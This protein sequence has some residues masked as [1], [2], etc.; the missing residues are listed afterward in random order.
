MRF[1]I[2]HFL[3]LFS[4]SFSNVIAAEK[5]PPTPLNFLSE[6]CLDCHD[7]DSAKGKINL[8]LLEIDWASPRHPKLLE[9][10]HR[11]LENG[12]MPPPKKKTQPGDDEREAMLGWLDQSLTK[13]IP[14]GGTPLR[15]LNRGEYVN[16]V[17][18]LFG[19]PFTLPPSFPPDTRLHGFDNQGEGLVL[20][21]PLL[22]A[23][24]ES[25]A[26]IADQFFPPPLPPVEKVRTDIR[27]SDMVISYSSAQRV[28]GA[29]RLGC[30]SAPMSR[31]C[32]WPTK[33]ETKGSGSYKIQVQSTAFKPRDDQPLKLQ[34]R[35]R[36]LD[37]NDGTRVD[38]LRLLAEFDV[39]AG[40][41][42]TFEFTADL[43]RGETLVY[44]FA[45]AELD[46]DN[47][48]KDE[49]R[50]LLE[51]MFRN[52]KRLLAAWMSVEHNQGLRGGV[53]WKRVKTQ[54]SRKDLDLSL[55]DIESEAAQKMIDGMIKNPVN[56]V[57]TIIYQYFEQGPALDIRKTIV[58]GPFE[59]VED[60]ATK[61]QKR[62]RADFLGEQGTK[63]EPEWIAAAIERF[64][65]QAFRRP[66][67]ANLVADYHKL[68]DQHRKEGHDLDASMH[69]VL[70]T[71]LTS[72]NF[73]YRDKGDGRLD[74]FEFASR[75]SYFL[76]S[77][78]PDN[79]LRDAALG[80]R[81]ANLKTVQF[82]AGRLLEDGASQNF[83]RSF[84]Q[85]WLGL[86]ELI[87]IMP[88]P[89]FG[90]FR[91]SDRK[92]MES[93]AEMFFAEMIRE[94]RP[95]ADF[96]TPDFTFTNAD[97]GAAIY[98][99]KFDKTQKK[100]G[101]QMIRVSLDPEGTYGGILGQAGVMM[102][103]ANGVD[104]QPVLRGV[105]VLENVLG[106][107]P[108]PPPEAVPAITPDTR[109]AKTVRDLM[110]AHTTEESCARCHQKIDPLGFVLENFNPIG[111][112]RDEYP[113]PGPKAKAR[114]IDATG[115]L[116]DGTPLKDVRDL[117]RY[118]VEHIDQFGACLAGKFFTYGTG[119]APNYT[120]GKQL[121]ALV[122]DT[123]KKGGGTRDLLM[124][125]ILS[126]AFR[127]K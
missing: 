64:L 41:P 13:N 68:F 60:P 73:L 93:E 28:G 117:K 107:P 43:Y 2:A 50:A 49:L 109:G 116:P 87:S 79:K 113:K 82:Q 78:P 25:A 53:G 3:A 62:R 104:T 61:A 58:E 51:N 71:A 38:T 111:Q 6:Y 9:K 30:K 124:G 29:M 55:G 90:R 36:P 59:Y 74:D 76:T 48:D 4:A 10:V 35:A 92:A 123:L 23:Y 19:I 85:Q 22:E 127:A 77:E 33:F 119:R 57:E 67:P 16:S 18:R 70:R 120:E 91:D 21:P 81:L 7:A 66:A 27:P 45:N 102:A 122:N 84:T 1:S 20:S 96:I 17:K 101:T 69:L 32:T 97:V 115:T 72:P 26:V 24:A 52:D 75:L 63:S 34:I 126:D 40:D 106:D 56:Y 12:E 47:E 11:V 114:P 110:A 100:K 103:T 112:W 14:V 121:Q 46:S 15:R 95:L 88:D 54:L 39:S 105:W 118:V 65:T 99:L 5:I 44:Y 80:G 86:H 83:I 8:D 108:P 37:A 31:S 89:K 98:D 125:I 94:N 42:Q